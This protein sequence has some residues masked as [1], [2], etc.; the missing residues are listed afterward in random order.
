[1]KQ[2]I[3]I[4][5]IKNALPKIEGIEIGLL[6]GS[7]ARKTAN[8]NSDIDLQI[9]VSA[10]FKVSEMIKVLQVELNEEQ[11]I[12]HQ[13]ASRSK[14][15]AYFKELPKIDI[16]IFHQLHELD[17]NFLGS[18]IK[19]IA[20]SILFEKEPEK[21]QIEKYLKE[22]SN[23][24]QTTKSTSEEKQIGDLIDKF[25]YEFES[26][27]TMHRRSDGYQ[28]YYFYNIAL[29]CAIQ[30]KHLSSGERSF[31]FLPKNF[32][33]N[34]MTGENQN[35]F[36][37]LKGTLFLPE[38]NQLKRRLLDFFY[39][40]IEN[41]VSN[42]KQSEI[43]QLCE[44]MYDRDF[45]WNFRD[46]S[47]NNPRIKSGLIFR[48]ATMSLFQNESNFEA[49]LD[50]K[51]I[52]TVI[53][54]RADREIEEL[55][56]TEQS[57]SKFNYV[58]AQL[59]PWNQPDWFEESH[60]HGT[61]EEIAYR[62][63]GMACNHKIKDAM[64]AIINEKEGA[65][66]IHCYAGKDRTGII[67]SLLHLLVDTPMDDV[68]A[69]YLASENDIHPRKLKIVLDIIEE[70]GGVKPYLINC[71]LTENQIEELRIKIIKE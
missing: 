29:H 57:L 25:I 18:E 17:R 53:D 61:N 35:D 23:Q 2:N 66:A 55:P 14:V 22:I 3:I 44:W 15:V 26:C 54:L 16:G 58:K 12:F 42:G 38:V 27:S 64:E 7:F 28:F 68:Y 69:D 19:E 6:I 40:S 24:C 21:Y 46:V 20:A 45:L 71:G 30:L 49:F 47:K 56:Y 43:K 48:T 36:Y 37:K 60:Q 32:I 11:P 5:K 67:V 62:F 59:D 41:L 63:F 51:N 10:E 8:P 34:V 39:S 31:N 1:M 33:V 65:S 52:K 4:E 9:L 70:K 50:G 13:V